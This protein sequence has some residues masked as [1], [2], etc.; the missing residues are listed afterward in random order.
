MHNDFNL[1]VKFQIDPDK[2]KSGFITNV[3]LESI[4]SDIFLS[5]KY[6]HNNYYVFCFSVYLVIEMKIKFVVGIKHEFDFIE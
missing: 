6:I 1:S 5:I 3:P 4:L 2:H